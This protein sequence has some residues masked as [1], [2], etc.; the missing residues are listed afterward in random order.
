MIGALET[1]AN[2]SRVENPLSP[3]KEGEDF[4]E[5]VRDVETT[6]IRVPAG[7]QDYYGAMY[8]GLQSLKWGYGQHQRNWLPQELIPELEKRILLFYSGQSRNSGINNWALFKGFIDGQEGVRSKFEKISAA[9]ARLETALLS[10]NWDHVGKAIAEEWDTRKTLATGIT[11]PEIDHA[12]SQAQKLGPISGKV[13]GAGGGGCFFVYL[14]SD[15]ET[16][17][18]ELRAEIEKIFIGQGMRPLKFHGVPHGLEVR[19]TRA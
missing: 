1:W 9:T 17:R 5:I 16:E 3:E 2:P 11:T 8:G 4:I 13:C 18:N 12:F 6:V 7:L 14:S 10:K 15:S 19:V